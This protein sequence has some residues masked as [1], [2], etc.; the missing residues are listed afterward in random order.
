MTHQHA[1]AEIR[2][3][4]RANG[5]AVGQRGRIPAEIARQYAA[6]QLEAANERHEQG[7]TA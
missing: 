7:G 2:A 4:A 6:A 1:P 3:W 5:I